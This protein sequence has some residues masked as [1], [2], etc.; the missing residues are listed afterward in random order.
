MRWDKIVFIII[1]VLMLFVNSKVRIYDIFLK[2]ILVYRNYRNNRISI[3]DLMC[4]IIFPLVL[5]VMSVFCFHYLVTPRLAGSLTDILALIFTILFGY[6]AIIA[7][8][9]DSLFA[10]NKDEQSDNAKDKN[11]SVNLKVL[12]RTA[13]ETYITIIN[14]TLLSLIGLINAVILTLIAEDKVELIET[15]SVLEFFLLFMLVMQLMMITKRTIKVVDNLN[16]KS[17]SK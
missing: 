15:L 1:I 11:S 4:F 10:D 8:R 7:E 14:A 6:E 9:G 13:Q 5:A 2:Q 16:K 3:W 12:Q 17:N